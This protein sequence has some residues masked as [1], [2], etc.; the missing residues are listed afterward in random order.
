MG[1]ISQ[2]RMVAAEHDDRYDT[3]RSFGALSPA[4]TE[5]L[6]RYP[7]ATI[8]HVEEFDRRTGFSKKVAALYQAGRIDDIDN[9][10]S[11]LTAQV[12]DVSTIM[13]DEAR[14]KATSYVQNSGPYELLA[15]SVEYPWG[16]TFFY[17]STEYTRTGKFTDQLV[18]HG[19]VVVDRYSGA[20]WP[21]G[22]A[23]TVDVYER[24][25]SPNEEEVPA[26]VV[27]YDRRDLGDGWIPAHGSATDLRFRAQIEHET[28]PG[29]DLF[30]ADPEV[31]AVYRN[32]LT[33]SWL[34]NNSRWALS[35]LTYEEDGN[36]ETQFFDSWVEVAT[37]APAFEQRAFSWNS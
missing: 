10:M 37:A 36:P 23:F 13:I 25:G 29:H 2:S 33:I 5:L 28:T 12:L 20:L 9:F 30:E 21:T 31:I 27:V 32:K 6:T 19:P 3:R 24:C 11:R 15:D 35:R 26:S 22:S 8:Q 7:D 4:A 1:S 18:G 17:Q 16:W 14:Q 34:P